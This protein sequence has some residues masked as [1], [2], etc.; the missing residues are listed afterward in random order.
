MCETCIACLDS[1]PANSGGYLAALQ[2]CI[3]TYLCQ[4]HLIH[5]DALSRF[6][7]NKYL[8]VGLGF[9]A[10]P[11]KLGHCSKQASCTLGRQHLGELLRDVTIEGKLLEF[12]KSKVTEAV[13]PSHELGLFVGGQ[14][15]DV[16]YFFGRR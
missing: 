14:E 1:L 3:K 9:L 16:L 6:G 15:L 2:L 4:R 10:L 8:V 11:V 7:H 12:W 13:M 5:R